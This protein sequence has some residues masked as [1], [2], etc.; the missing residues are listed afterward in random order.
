MISLTEEELEYADKMKKIIQFDQ[1]VDIVDLV[2]ESYQYI[3]RNANQKIILSNLCLKLEK[4]MKGLPLLSK[5]V[6]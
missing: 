1:L 5:E 6:I 4:V 2:G 3:K